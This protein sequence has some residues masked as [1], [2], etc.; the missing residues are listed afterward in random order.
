MYFKKVSESQQRQSEG[1][2]SYIPSKR[3]RTPSPVCCA[4]DKQL[5][6]CLLYRSRLKYLFKHPE[7]FIHSVISEKFSELHNIQYRASIETTPLDRLSIN[8]PSEVTIE[9]AS[10][11]L[12][13]LIIHS[14]VQ[15]QSNHWIFITRVE[16]YYHNKKIGDV[17]Q[18]D[19]K[20]KYY[21][22]RGCSPL[23]YRRTSI[24]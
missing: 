10:I 22:R 24:R 17:A 14:I 15:T 19:K 16:V 12:K 3:L 18:I 4:S 20:K 8:N 23:C 11:R 2:I 1:S 9:D 21:D 6:D 7:D 5:E 13:G